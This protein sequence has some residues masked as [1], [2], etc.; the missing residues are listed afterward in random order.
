MY[1][2]RVLM[3]KEVFSHGCR[4]LDTGMLDWIILSVFCFNAKFHQTKQNK[5]LWIPYIICGIIS[6]HRLAR[7]KKFS[8]AKML[9]GPNL[10]W[11]H[12]VDHALWE[13]IPSAG[14]I[15]W[16]VHLQPVQEY[17]SSGR[18]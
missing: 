5:W 9:A 2:V 10:G 1:V 3:H 8:Q 18:R 6:I 11:V 15:G 13:V 4:Q 12:Q 7:G 14:S 16:L 17:L